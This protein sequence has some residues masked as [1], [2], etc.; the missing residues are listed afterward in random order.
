MAAE[1]SPAVRE[2]LASVLGETAHTDRLLRLG[3]LEHGPAA[4]RGGESPALDEL[5]PAL[6][7]LIDKVARHAYTITDDDVARARAA[8]CSDDALYDLVVATAVG[9]G[10]AR[11]SLG[12]AAVARWE[13]ER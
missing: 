2:L 7:E 3:V 13:R 11:R 9:A 8:G 6:A 5:E 4:A 10:L 1:E 12:R